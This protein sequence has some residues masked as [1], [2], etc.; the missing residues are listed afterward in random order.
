MTSEELDKVEDTL[1]VLMR[2]TKQFF[3]QQIHHFHL[4]EEQEYLV[5]T[6]MMEGMRFW[7]EK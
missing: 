3:E 5:R 1:E 2:L 7:S 4:N 6:R